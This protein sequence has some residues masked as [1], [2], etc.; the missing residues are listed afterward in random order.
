[1]REFGSIIGGKQQLSGAW[2]EVRN[3]F[4]NEVVG[5]VA[6]VDRAATLAV[7]A[8]TR[9]A[10]VALPRHQRH[11]LLNRI[12][13]RLEDDADAVSRLITDEAGLCL[14]DTKYEV[15]RASD[16]LR[17]AAI[18]TLLDDSEVFPCDVSKVGRPR[19]IYTMRQ[20][21]KLLA[22]ITPFNHP[23]NQ[24]VH[25]LAP[26]IATNNTTVLKPS[27]LTPLA[28]Y[29]IVQLALDCGMPPD[30][31]NVVSGSTADVAEAIVASELVDMITFTGSAAVGKRILA[32]AG[33]KR[34]VLELGGS[35][36]ML[37]LAD[38]DVALAADIAIAGV[39][40]NSGQRCTAIRRLLVHESIAGQF[41][42]TLAEKTAALRYGDPYDPQ[43]DVGTVISEATARTIEQRVNDSIAQGA[44]LLVGHRRAG[45]VYAPTVLDFVRND[46]ALVAS[47][48]F[49]PVAPIL[50][51]TTLD[52]AIAI[53][54]D[55]E[56]G[57][58]GAVVSNHWPS[59]QR[60][61]TELETGTVNVNEAPSYRL[62][63]SPFGGIKSSG[64]GYKEGVIDAMKSMTYVKTYSLPWDEP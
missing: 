56:F 6:A 26:A 19:R 41:A 53:A 49:G 36:A 24:V 28:A 63:W 30:M 16:V 58:S 39:F 54:N 61:I 31:I 11:D 44:K 35:S 27:L 43:T 10:K 34:V 33:Y 9:A 42:R 59:I 37:I 12:A 40:K 23:L 21:L 8:R 25:K 13:S 22:A 32:L 51:F 60:V 48:T 57:L 50:R 47:E 1:M 52:E 17:F 20:P 29:Y 55:T 62:E 38:A 64:L 3:P 14:K 7:V 15:A 18:Q 46:H 5:R 4:S 2:I 45:A